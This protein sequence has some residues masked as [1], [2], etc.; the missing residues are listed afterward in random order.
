MASIPKWKCLYCPKEVNGVSPGTFDFCPGC[1]KDQKQQ[2]VPR[3]SVGQCVTPNCNATLAD[4]DSA[5][6]CSTCKAKQEQ[7]ATSSP[8]SAQTINTPPTSVKEH[9]TRI[10]EAVMSKKQENE[11]AGKKSSPIESG[12]LGN[13]KDNTKSTSVTLEG[14]SSLEHSRSKA[15]EV[16]AQVPTNSG[17]KPVPRSSTPPVPPGTGLSELVVNRASVSMAHLNSSLKQ[18]N[19]KMDTTP[20][21]DSSTVESKE[22]AHNEAKAVES[23]NK[24]IKSQSKMCPVAAFYCLCVYVSTLT[25]FSAVQI[26]Y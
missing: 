16:G 20:A 21:P 10:A 22:K 13:T 5:T 26:R 9:K 17:N 15:S 4:S 8:S 19:P 6:L 23:G 24:E 25:A 14:P 1:G 18:Q 12:D 3:V 7:V 11:S 2:S